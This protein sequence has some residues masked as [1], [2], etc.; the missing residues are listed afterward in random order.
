MEAWEKDAASTTYL[1]TEVSPEPI[2]MPELDA[3]MPLDQAERLYMLIEECGEVIQAATKALRHGFESYHPDESVDITNR[4]QLED[5]ITD[6]RAVLEMMRQAKDLNMI[7]DGVDLSSVINR[8]LRYTHYQP[9]SE[10][11]NA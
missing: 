4:V 10:N 9:K 5:E 6:L 11:P 7:R 2:P 1:E 8:K 3:P